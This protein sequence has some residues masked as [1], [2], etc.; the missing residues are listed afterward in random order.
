MNLNRITRTAAIAALAITALSNSTYAQ[1][2][3]VAAEAAA[4]NKLAAK[5]GSWRAQERISGDFSA[6]AGSRG[7]A[8]KL[9]AGLRRARP[10]ALTSARGAVGRDAAII[11][12]PTGPMSYGDIYTAL[13]LTRQRLAAQG[14]SNPTP[15]QIQFTLVG[16][17]AKGGNPPEARTLQGILRL[18]SRGES[19]P[20]IADAFG[21]KLGSVLRSMKAANRRL[22][23]RTA[24]TSASAARFA[25]AAATIATGANTGSTLA[26]APNCGTDLDLNNREAISGNNTIASVNAY[27]SPYASADARVDG[28]SPDAIGH[29]ASL[30]LGSGMLR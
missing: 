4:M 19:W 22:S 26:P 23:V 3:S 13:A 17:T 18:R 8:R 1:S 29:L 7:N 24:T 27:R 25:P 30:S 21:L 16:G 6:F 12:P 2:D 20:E 15:W 5:L 28:A 11:V 9:V 10:V 14:I